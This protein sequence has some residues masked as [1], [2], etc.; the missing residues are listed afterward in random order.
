[1]ESAYFAP[2][3]IHNTSHK[4]GLATQSSYRFERGVDLAC[5]ELAA[6]RAI[7]LIQKLACSG[8]KKSKRV[9]VGRP[10]DKG[11]K[12]LKQHKVRLRFA[13][14]SESLGM[15]VSPAQIK[16][17][18]RKIQF[19]FAR[20]SK[21]S[22][23]VKIPSFRR[24]IDREADLIEE[25]ARLY[26]YDKIPSRVSQLTPDLS[27]TGKLNLSSEETYGIIRQA[28]LSLGLNEIMSYS[29]IS[30]QALRKL[31]F[32]GDNTIA[33]K[34]PLSYEQE[35][36]RPTLLVGMLNALLTNI[37]RKNTDLKLFE[38]SRIYLRAS[39]S[40]EERTNLCIGIAGKRSGSWLE[41]QGEY[42]FFDLK[43]VTKTLL[44]KLGVGG[45]RFRE[46]DSPYFIA[47]RCAS[48]FLGEENAGFLGEVKKEILQRFDI[49][50]PVYT[51]ELRL[52]GLL[53]HIR[54]ER[55]F[56]P[57]A[58]FPSIERDVSLVAP[59]EILSEQITSLI[60]KIGRERVT[61]VKLFDQYFGEQIPQGFRGLSFS[62]EYRASDRTLTAEEVEKLH[63]QI[64]RALAEE[65]KVQVR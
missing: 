2:L 56:V 12:S 5:V 41:K 38:L 49:S 27:Y 3:N 32:S 28:L 53:P 59:Q 35:M 25:V 14:V 40:T 51:A 47:G 21:E 19:T 52:Q 15:E 23:T 30:R 46:G 4:L 22:I 63:A 18:L 9:I 17:L 6:S 24:D 10:I 48:I 8:Q 65:L 43:G 39:Q 1:L 37:N 60:N 45:F 42:S 31:E 7:K 57:L 36:L 62:I 20:K 58:R 29:L 44:E 50:C 55:R 26:G 16:K 13:K 33:I 11:K 64:R 61:Q 34:N 54:R